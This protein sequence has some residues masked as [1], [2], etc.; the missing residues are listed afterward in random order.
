MLT[1]DYAAERAA[2]C[3]ANMIATIVVTRLMMMMMLM[4]RFA[5]EALRYARHAGHVAAT[6]RAFAAPPIR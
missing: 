1:L 2:R 5:A 4:L 6:L 3:Y